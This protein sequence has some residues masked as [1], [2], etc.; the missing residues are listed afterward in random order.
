MAAV[1]TYIETSIFLLLFFFNLSLYKILIS[2]QILSFIVKKFLYFFKIYYIYKV[3]FYFRFCPYY[4]LP[5]INIF[6]ILLLSKILLLWLQCNKI[7]CL[8]RVI[9]SN[10]LRSFWILFTLRVT[11]FH[12]KSK[13]LSLIHYLN[14][15]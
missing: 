15:F 2:I 9:S 7:S 6:V 3:F 8:L 12:V 14:L 4:F 10:H 1:S 11:F 13:I 5:K